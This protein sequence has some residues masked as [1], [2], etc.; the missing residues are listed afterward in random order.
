MLSEAKI[1]D[2][3]H[4]LKFT[5]PAYPGLEKELSIATKIDFS[6]ITSPKFIQNSWLVTNDFRYLYQQAD[7][8]PPNFL[9]VLASAR[10]N[11]TISTSSGFMVAAMP[12]HKVFNLTMPAN[13]LITGI[14]LE[15]R[16]MNG[17]PLPMEQNANIDYI[18]ILGK[19][20]LV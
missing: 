2:F 6:G 8:D 9:F 7:G 14:Y 16:T 4:A 1:R 5:P 20:N 17:V 13:T 19:A 18:A 11:I 10:F 3:Q 15:G 12:V